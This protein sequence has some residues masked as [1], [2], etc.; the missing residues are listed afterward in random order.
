[1]RLSNKDTGTFCTSGS[2]PDMR[3][4]AEACHKALRTDAIASEKVGADLAF[5]AAERAGVLWSNCCR[6]AARAVQENKP[7]RAG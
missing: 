1:M 2:K 3:K 4:V 7:K 5:Q 6:W